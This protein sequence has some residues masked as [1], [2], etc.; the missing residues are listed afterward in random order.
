MICKKNYETKKKSKKMIKFFLQNKASP[1]L[2]DIEGI[3]ALHIISTNKNISFGNL[4]LMIEHKAEINKVDKFGNFPIHYICG[5]PFITPIIINLFDYT[6]FE[7]RNNEY[8]TPFQIVLFFF[9]FFLFF[10]F[11][12]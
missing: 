1:N 7:K 3:S 5:N 4:N 11:F 2:H 6:S 12:I 9:I 10:I 8:R